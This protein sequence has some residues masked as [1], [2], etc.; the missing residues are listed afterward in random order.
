MSAEELDTAAIRAREQAATEGPWR[1][2][3][4]GPSGGDHWYVCDDGESIAL[5][6]ASDG[7]DE[8]SR[9]P[10]AQFIAHART[11]VPALLNEVARLRKVIEDALGF[12]DQTIYANSDNGASVTWRDDEVMNLLGDVRRVLVR[13]SSDP[14]SAVGA[15]NEEGN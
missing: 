15:N 10:D 6:H 9:E 4:S 12:I 2:I 7:E 1:A 8:D 3:T 13:E 14:A 11:D 5:I